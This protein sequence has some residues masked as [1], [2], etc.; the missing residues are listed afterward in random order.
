MGKQD[1]DGIVSRRSGI[2]ALVSNTLDPRIEERLVYQ[3]KMH[4]D[5]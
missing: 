1:S 4:L 5:P 2:T 3:L